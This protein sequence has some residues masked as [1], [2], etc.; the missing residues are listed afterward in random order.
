MVYY[1]QLRDNGKVFTHETKEE[2]LKEIYKYF[3]NHPYAK[4]SISVL[5]WDG[6]KNQSFWI[7]LESVEGKKA[8]THWTGWNKPIREVKSDGKLGRTIGFKHIRN[9]EG[10]ITTT[11]FY[12]KRK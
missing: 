10:L 12:W 6:K 11:K 4:N 3:K 5:Y 9:S 1:Y 7:S 2:A 8:I